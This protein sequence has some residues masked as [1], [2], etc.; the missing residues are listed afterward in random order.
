MKKYIVT[1]VTMLIVISLGGCDLREALLPKLIER[2]EAYLG[3]EQFTGHEFKNITDNVYEFRWNYYRNISIDTEEGWVII[4]PIN[5]E[6]ASLLAK[7]LKRLKPNKPVAALI[8]SHYHLDHAVGGKELSPMRVI[9]HKDAP[10]YWKD[11]AKAEQGVLLPTELIDG[12]VTLKFGSTEIRALYLENS[13]TDTLYAFHLPQHRL[14]FSIDLGMVKSFLP[15]GH[16]D[17]YGPGVMRALDR[18]A[19][20]DFD[21]FIPAH[22]QTGTK[23]DL[24]EH[25]QS[26]RD[27]LRLSQEAIEMYGAGNGATIPGEGEELV[28][29]F[30]HIYK[31]MK[32]KYGHWHGFNEQS[33]YIVFTSIVRE[34]LGF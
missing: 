14:L 29:M 27:L 13:H 23:D 2:Q 15:M 34:T 4:D 9:G 33:L 21:I 5:K 26:K 19:S 12:D 24:L 17:T 28:K 3:A 7:E 31:P 16:P 32:E 6:A 25:I 18:L 22:F 8:Y 11:F 30:M 20:L 1:F 10:K